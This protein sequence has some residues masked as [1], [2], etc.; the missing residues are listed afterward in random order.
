[1]KKQGDFYLKL[2]S[3]LMAVL[4]VAYV[5]CSLVMSSDGAY[6]LETAVYCEVGDGITVSGF[7]VRSEEVLV[8]N[9]PIVVCELTEGER[10]G[11]G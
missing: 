6:T 10:V 3:I 4:L 8:S 9:S 2:T 1:M 7:V 5:V 11:G